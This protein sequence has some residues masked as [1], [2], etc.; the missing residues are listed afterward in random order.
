MDGT[1]VIIDD[2]NGSLLF[3]EG[4]L[5]C[6]FELFL[7]FRLVFVFVELPLFLELIWIDWGLWV[8]GNFLVDDISF[9]GLNVFKLVFIF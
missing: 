1:W 6:C 8:D 2:N 5:Y 3:E 4:I 7:E 9:G